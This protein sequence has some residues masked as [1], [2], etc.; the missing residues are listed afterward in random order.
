MSPEAPVETWRLLK[1]REMAGQMRGDGDFVSTS[2][3]LPR[4]MRLAQTAPQSSLC[5]GGVLSEN[6]NMKRSRS[7]NH[8]R[9]SKWLL[10]ADQAMGLVV[11]LATLAWLVHGM[12]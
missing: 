8:G 9:L 5:A 10:V 12:L 7:A 3:A 4:G 11:K 1:T 2:F 6:T